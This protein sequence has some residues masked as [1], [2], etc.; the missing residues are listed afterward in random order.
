MKF[1]STLKTILIIFGFIVNVIFVF[2][3]FNKNKYDIQD[4]YSR[5]KAIIHAGILSLTS[6][7]FVWYYTLYFLQDIIQ[8]DCI[9]AASNIMYGTYMLSITLL[10][11]N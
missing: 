4:K 1:L 3:I 5:K 8:Y 9:L 10:I 2:K 11:T 6:S 7:F